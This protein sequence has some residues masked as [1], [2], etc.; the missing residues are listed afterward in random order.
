MKVAA[1][2]CCFDGIVMCADSQ[3]TT[4]DKTLFTIKGSARESDEVCILSGFPESDEFGP[5]GGQPLCF[6]QEI[7]QIAVAATTP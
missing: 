4:A 2:F 3:E 5:G 6:Q 7:I 1:G